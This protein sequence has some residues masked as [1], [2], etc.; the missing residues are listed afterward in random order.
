MVSN[1]ASLLPRMVMR[2]SAADHLNCE[3]L[4]CAGLEAITLSPTIEVRLV[5]N[6]LAAEDY[7]RILEQL[8]PEMV[9]SL[10][11]LGAKLNQPEALDL[12]YFRS[13]SVEAA[14]VADLAAKISFALAKLSGPF[15]EFKAVCN[16]KPSSLMAPYGKATTVFV[17]NKTHE[18]YPITG[19]PFCGVPFTSYSTLTYGG[20]KSIWIQK[21]RAQITSR[22]RELTLQEHPHKAL[23][24]DGDTTALSC[25]HRGPFGMD[26][27][28]ASG[29]GSMDFSTAESIINR[30]GMMCHGFLLGLIMTARPVPGLLR[31]ENLGFNI[32]GS[33][34]IFQSAADLDSS[35]Y[36]P[37][38][39]KARTDVNR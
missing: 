29:K 3:L 21:F 30:S 10:L 2:E 5:S 31:F 15:S 27:G 28:I 22:F 13:A 12:R 19:Y 20:L 6:G 36:Y 35:T 32:T 8:A 34:T 25:L 26:A 38:D 9:Q 37:K 17:P 16:D 4:K 14:S 23:G 33:K 1:A 24:Y 11:D 18:A 39:L 7:R